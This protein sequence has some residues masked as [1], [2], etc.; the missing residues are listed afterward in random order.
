MTQISGGITQMGSSLIAEHA[1]K[2]FPPASRSHRRNLR[3]ESVKSA[4]RS[5]LRRGPVGSS[6]V[7]L[8]GLPRGATFL[9]AMRNTLHLPPKKSATNADGTAS[10]RTYR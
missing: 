8:T 10:A 5:G 4:V 1:S 3:E 7:S 9:A 2:R 6:L